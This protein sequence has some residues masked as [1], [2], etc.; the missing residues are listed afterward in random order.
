MSDTETDQ[1]GSLRVSVRRIHRR[2]LN[3]VWEFLKKVFRDVNRET[4]EYQRPR[5]KRRFIET[6]DQDD[7]E[8][9][10]FEVDK[11]VVGYAE[12]A[13]DASGEDNWINPRYFDKR[14]MRPLYVE[15]LAVHPDYQ[16]QGVGSF[17]LDQLQHLARV[18]GCTHL[19]LEV[20]ENNK[21]ALSWYRKRNFYRLDAAIFMAQ[22]L[23]AEPEL[24]PPRK[25]VQRRL[26]AG[27]EG[28]GSS[29]PG[30]SAR[31]SSRRTRRAAGSARAASSRTRKRTAGKSR[32][33]KGGPQKSAEKR[34]KAASRRASPEPVHLVQSAPAERVTESVGPVREPAATEDV[35]PTPEPTA[36][37]GVA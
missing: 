37:G 24:L 11:E 26:P 5:S 23:P 32:R 22:K 2:D 12:C 31:S 29:R 1:K 20:A 13:F 8:Q 9:L 10:L 27:E 28:Q 30:K 16:G 14:G 7:I 33:A 34:A 6:Y 19:V 15:E 36:S 18:R 17:M 3:R 4:V 21:V 35:L 25:L